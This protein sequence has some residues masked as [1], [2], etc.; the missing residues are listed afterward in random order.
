MRDSVAAT[1]EGRRLSQ[2]ASDDSLWRRWGPYVSAR[3]W[4]TVRED[5]SAKGDAW[6]SFPFDR[7]RQRAYR[8]GEDGLGG[9]CDRDGFLN[10]A[11]ALWNTHDDRLK[12]RLF[13]LTGPEGNHAEDVKEYY[14]ALD[15]TPT[16]S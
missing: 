15:A 16:H 8:W 2:S 6:T 9:L 1:E 14:W 3:Q 10:L 13:G 12:E 4:G 5:Y 11:M 7:A